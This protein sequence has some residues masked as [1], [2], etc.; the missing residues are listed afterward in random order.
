MLLL[1]LFWP[2]Q[3]LQEMILSFLQKASRFF[4]SAFHSILVAK[5]LLALEV[6]VYQALLEIQTQ[7]RLI[8]QLSQE[9]HL[10]MTQRVVH[11]RLLLAMNLMG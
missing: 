6:V 7:I 8:H 1:T 3:N 11:S 9:M 5:E 2:K 4:V 10:L